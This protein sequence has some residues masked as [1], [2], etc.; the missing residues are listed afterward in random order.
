MVCAQTSA[1]QQK[2]ID[3]ALTLTGFDAALEQLEIAY[4]RS[5]AASKAGYQ[6][7]DAQL[8]T[9]QQALTFFNAAAIKQKLTEQLL[10]QYQERPMQTLLSLQKDNIAA[11]FLRYERIASSPR[12]QEK[13][14]QYVATMDE[15][16]FSDTRLA[17]VRALKE[18]THVVSIAALIQAQAD[19]DSAV[20]L[21][22]ASAEFISAGDS[23]GVQLW[24]RTLEQS[25]LDQFEQLGDGYQIY[26]YRWIKNDELRQH[27]EFLQD[28]NVQWFMEATLESLRQVLQKQRE[29]LV[30]ALAP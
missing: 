21:D 12:Q 2:D 5:L 26:T 8:E 14:E 30:E 4:R 1:A 16:P 20:A 15:H 24:Q 29:Q 23:Q 22:M 6:L 7:S 11:K 13:M 18:A 9:L 19:V 3:A 28:K 27:V 17:L 25:Y 10:P